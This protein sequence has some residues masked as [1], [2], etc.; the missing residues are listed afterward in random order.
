MAITLLQPFNLDP[1]KD[2]TFGN[3]TANSA[4]LGNSVT[5]NYFIGNGALLTGIS[6]GSTYSNSN[7]AAYLPTYT[8]NISAN[9]VI[10]NGSTL[11]S[12]TGANV[13]GYVALSTTANTAST[14]TTA[15]Q[16]NITSVGTLTSLAITGNVTSGNANLGNVVVANY[17][18]GNGSLLTGISG[19]YSNSNVASYLPT[20]TG[21]V[22]ANYF[23]G[24]GSQLTSINI[25]NIAGSYSNSNV[26][27]YLPT[28]S[29]NLT[30]GNANVS[31]TMS[32]ASITTTGS[33][34][35]ITG[36]DYINAN[37]YIGNGSLL[38]GL[39]A[40]YSNT[41]VAAYLP[42]Y[43]GNVSANYFIGNGS[44]LTGLPAS[45]SNAN[46]AAYLPTYSGNLTAG[47]IAT[48][49]SGGNL[50]GANYVISNYF[51]GNGS[52]L[53]SI[54]GANV[55]GYVPLSTTANVAGTVT[56]A[57]QPN[58]TSTGTLL[59]LSVTG[60][61][62]IT[63]N[64][65][66][67]GNLN[68]SNVTD[69]VVGDPLIYLGANNTGNLYDLGIVASYNDGTYYHTGLARD[70]TDGTWKLFDTVV[71]EPTTTIDFA[72]GTYAPFQTGAFTSTGNI[73]AGNINAGNL[74][75]ANYHSGNG[76]LL[77]SLT[78][79]NVTGYVP[80]ATA[81]NT[82]GTVTT[83]AQPNI[84]SV[85]TL[86]S[87]TVSGLITATGTGIKTANIQDST[88]TVTITTKYNNIAGD[89]GVYGNLTVG[90]SGSGNVTASYFIGDGS[91]LTNVPTANISN[92][93]N[94]AGT[95]TTN[96]QPNITSVG[97]LTGFTS[98]GVID[99]TNTSNVSLGN[100]SNLH[101]TGGSANYVLKT[102]GTGNL[103]WT[104]QSGGGGGTG[105]TY[106][107]ATTPPGTANV[108]DQWYNTT[109]N[110][111]YEYMSDGTSTYWVDI[112]SPVT[113]SYV[114][115]G[116]INRAYTANGTGTTYT[117]TSGCGV[118]DVLV[119]ING[120]CQ[121]P[122][123]DYT[124]SGAVLTLGSTPAANTVIQ[125]RELPR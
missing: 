65:N 68:Y 14:V 122:T 46:V 41:N 42:T 56:T 40:S 101:I 27:S 83:N 73:S 48:S 13:T 107:T 38:T 54:T 23:I 81:A 6:A 80:S 7:V 2:F 89:A 120:I 88:G 110:T 66:A 112:Q 49:G 77:T 119:F 28:Y 33:A 123:T 100:V 57:A 21:N 58:I 116:Y 63:G 61:L 25:S 43:T 62:N 114:T 4:N 121:M 1:T 78:G 82:A 31:G 35:N 99:F 71:A 106:T 52:L 67:T 124:I 74:L 104:A 20:Y 103:S 102:D 86:S 8:G 53:T 84:T 98:N 36:A 79:A 109:T 105:I 85:G 24:N 12:I 125:I 37:F 45:Y 75:I 97:T 72:N 34:G 29:G 26:A 93:A 117:V 55:T 17:F 44:L 51:I 76:S 30:A 92:T 69:L 19:T 87:L 10:G 95:V 64:I 50:S 22:S 111:L 3:V 113:A 39:P 18:S 60:N 5:A 108:A 15:D 32:V 96:A 16:P 115:S 11:T 47:N 70:A 118:N 90:T 91:Q 9:Y 59:G 94:T